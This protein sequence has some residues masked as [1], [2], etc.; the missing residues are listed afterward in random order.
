MAVAK[1]LILLSAIFLHG[2]ICKENSIFQL[3]NVSFGN[4]SRYHALGLFN[5]DHPTRKRVAVRKCS[6]FNYLYPLKIFSTEQPFFC[7]A[8]FVS[9]DSLLTSA[10][11]LKMLQQRDE[12]PSNHMFVILDQEDVFFYE[13]GRRYVSKVFV[14]P[15]F[16]EE[17]AYYNVAVV[18]LRHAVY[19]RDASGRSHL[20]CLWS[21]SRLKNSNAVLGEWFELQP[22]QNPTFRWL[23][24]PFVAQEECRT[25]LSK[26]ENPVAELNQGLKDYQICVRDNRNNTVIQFCE[27]RSSGPLFMTLGSTVYLVGLPT[28]HI[29]DCGVEVEVFNQIH[30]FLD[31]I[32]SVVWPGQE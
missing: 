32:E 12:H 7:P 22:E 15:K 18:K 21:E 13:N 14:H 20:S 26:A 31:W 16:E 27:A 4:P 17:P 3:R 10:L 8:V 6:S 24:L 29:D 30:Y 28:V 9:A 19:D 25:E 2:A 11:C 1:I 5:N 23:D